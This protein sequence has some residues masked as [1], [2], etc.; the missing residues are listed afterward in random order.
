MKVQLLLLCLIPL[1]SACQAHGPTRVEKDFGVSVRQMVE[2]QK[3]TPGETVR[4]G[5]QLPQPLDGVKAVKTIDRYKRSAERASA[6]FKAAKRSS[7][8]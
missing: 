4:T 7:A 3:Y 8:Q 6:Q 1:L 2:E 5:Q